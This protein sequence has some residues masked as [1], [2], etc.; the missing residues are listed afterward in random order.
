MYSTYKLDKL[1]KVKRTY[2]LDH[3]Q[4]LLAHPLWSAAWNAS[5]ATTEPPQG[6]GHSREVVH[7]RELLRKALRLRNH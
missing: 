7:D 4:L 2:G 3:P 6:R 1:S 5:H